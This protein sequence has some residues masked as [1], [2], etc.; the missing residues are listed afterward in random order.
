[1]KG[2]LE[3]EENF[4]I[5]EIASKNF[6]EEYKKVLDTA[7][8]ICENIFIFNHKWDMEVCKKPYKFENNITWNIVPYGDPEW[9]FMLNRHKFWLDLGKAYSA[10][11]NE[12]YARTFFQQINSWIDTV[13]IYSKDFEKCSRTI[14][15]GIR[16]LNWI[17]SIEYFRTSKYY[18][19]EVEKKISDNL[20]KQCEILVDL[21]DDFRTLSNWGVM[22]NAGLVVF[23]LVYDSYPKTSKILKLALERLTYQC[24]IQILP[25]GIH[26]EQS[27][28]YQNEV[29]NCLLDVGIVLQ[30]NGIE[31]PKEI[32]DGIAKLAYS[33][34]YMA[35]PNHHQPMQGDSD[36]TDLRDIIT[37][38]AYLLKDGNLK[39]GGYSKID[40]ESLW[41][42]GE[43][44]LEI[45]NSISIGDMEIKS[46]EMR[47]SGNFYL[48][49]SYSED[50]NYM[51]F[52]CGAIGSGHGHGEHLNIDLTVYGENMIS[53][54]GRC[55]YVEEDERRN[56]LRSVYAHNTTLVD[57]KEFS[58]FIGAWGI[59]N[60]A[61]TLNNKFISEEKFDYVESGHLGYL[62]LEK[63]VIV[64]RK[65]LYYKPDIW[66]IIDEFQGEGNHRYNQIFNFEPGR[67][68]TVK[69]NKSIIQ[70]E[71]ST[72]NMQWFENIDLNIE[73]G[74]FS[75]EYNSVEKNSKLVTE[76]QGNGNKIIITLMTGS[77]N[78]DNKSYSAK[79][80]DVFRGDGTLVSKD[81]ARAV[82]ITLSED[83][84]IIFVN[85]TKD[86]ANQKKTYLVDDV[87][88]YGKV[89]LI[90]KEKNNVDLKILKY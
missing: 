62:N 60:S 34:M 45:Y 48:R 69:Q 5:A 58:K 47:E 67:K 59:L 24:K 57:G 7:D 17:K 39:I 9:T 85:G 89:A 43:K 13:D 61:Y 35:K 44:S 52:R 81:E 22:Q 30:N 20:Y 27:P 86:I 41:E 23:S 46:I 42:L 75:R 79:E 56:Y 66:I 8:L 80:I 74:L 26:W 31:I 50:G 68:I 54:P 87:I 10:T 40:F 83:K 90:I 78:I 77:K 65:I 16:C 37:R 76:T 38:A 71:N 19:K 6:P 82:E 32:E 64:F 18:S 3:K 12:K 15:M 11:K 49:D 72:L 88:Y 63:G 25:D 1:M 36:D 33:D 70:G 73:E 14:E 29:L 2:F 21:Y 84:K 4:R 51:W 28:M 55:T 53:D